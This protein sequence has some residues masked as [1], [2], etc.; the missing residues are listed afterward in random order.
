MVVAAVAAVVAVVVA[1]AVAVAVAVVDGGGVDRCSFRL[2]T[3]STLA[4]SAGGWRA[5]LKVGSVPPGGGG[6]NGHFGGRSRDRRKGHRRFKFRLA[7]GG[8]TGELRP[9]YSECFPSVSQSSCFPRSD[10]LEILGRI[11]GIVTIPGRSCNWAAA[12]SW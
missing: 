1:V 8:S 11:Y 4:L 2:F 5:P 6:V 10:S 12:V 7:L 9:D 3:W